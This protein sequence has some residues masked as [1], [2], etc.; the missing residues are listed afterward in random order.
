MNP[1]TS[2]TIR[3]LQMAPRLCWPLNTGAKLRNFQLA[4]V[5]SD[6]VPITFLGFA[7]EGE[8]AQKLTET[9][10]QVVA[11]PRDNHNSILNIAR[12]AV[13]TVPLPLRNYTTGAMKRQL[14]TVLKAESFDVVQFES[15]HLLGYLPL[16]RAAETRLPLAIL[17]WHNIE[18]D[19]LLQYSRRERNSLRRAYAQRTA[20]LMRA[21]EKH[22]TDVFDA[23]VV[24]SETDAER[25]RQ[26]NPEAR[27]F[28]IEN[29]VDAA[30]YAQNADQALRTANRHRIVF[31]G[32]MDYHANIDAAVHFARNSWPNV[33]AQKPELVFTIVGKDPAPAVRA[34][35]SIPGIEVTGSVEDVRPY[36]R[37]AIAAAVPLNVGGG[38]RLKILEAMA[39]GV[40]VVSTRVGAEGL[41]V[42]HEEN[43]LLTDSDDDFA[44]AIFRLMNDQGLSTRI[45]SGGHALVNE[46]YD[47][48]RVGGKLLNLYQQL[49]SER[50]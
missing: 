15:I 22:A 7:H 17:D 30:Y 5:L 36:Y 9:Y 33:Y 39:A 2:P 19:V 8:E 20:R 27:V 1:P 48:S 35:S 31:V 18:S 50:R 4:R 45:V 42:R 14:Q 23:H 49:V 44:N 24:V 28:V 37:E 13:G 29:G 12:G 38:S 40:P 25:L 3:L 10:Q 11:V 46:R 26:L 41:H 43:I 34:L 21:A 16:V 47:W 32:S 6:Q